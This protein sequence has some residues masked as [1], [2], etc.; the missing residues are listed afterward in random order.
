MSKDIDMDAIIL[1]LAGIAVAVIVIFG[2]MTL[3]KKSFKP[4][5][6]KTTSDTSEMY[7]EQRRQTQE[8]QRQQDQMMRGLK[9]RIRDGRR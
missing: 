1:T 2:I 5:L 9:Q 7:R 4:A 3:I 6:Q 8:T